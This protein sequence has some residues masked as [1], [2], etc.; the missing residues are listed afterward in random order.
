MA[1]IIRNVFDNSELPWFET[2][3]IFSINFVTSLQI[4]RKKWIETKKTSVIWA[5]AL[6]VYQKQNS[7]L[8]M[9]EYVW[10]FHLD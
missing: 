1:K 6:N 7:I 3:A 4:F 2:S 8:S 5:D 9:S 10:K